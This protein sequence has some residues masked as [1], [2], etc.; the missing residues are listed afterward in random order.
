MGA[1]ALTAT[2]IAEV[3]P[4]EGTLTVNAYVISPEQEMLVTLIA[5]DADGRTVQQSLALPVG[6][7]L[8]TPAADVSLYNA[9]F[10]GAQVISTV[11][12][13]TPVVVD[14]RNQDGSWLRVRLGGFRGWGEAT[15]FTC[16]SAFAINALQPDPTIPQA[17]PTPA[18]TVCP[19]RHA[20]PAHCPARRPV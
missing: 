3:L 2:A 5:Q 11:P 19:L 4:A 1:E 8:C 15:A 16:S 7:P 18:A 9:P 12:A 6:D 17:S 13:G 10:A 14:A 20:H